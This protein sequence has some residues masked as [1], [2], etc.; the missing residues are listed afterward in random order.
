MEGWTEAEPTAALPLLTRINWVSMWIPSNADLKLYR[1]FDHPIPVKSILP[2]ASNSA[3]VAAHKFMP[4][5]SFQKKWR[6]A[7]KVIDGTLVKRPP[8]VR[9]IRYPCRKDAY[10]FKYYRE[11]LAARYETLLVKESIAHCVLAYRQIPKHPHTDVCKSNIEF[12]K[13][14]IEA[15][16]RIGDCCVVAIDISDFF[17]S[18]DHDRIK[19]TWANLL[20][21]DHLPEDHFSVFK[22]LTRFSYADRDA[23]YVALGFSKRETDGTLRYLRHPDSI[24]LQICS[25][26]QFREKIVGGGL[27][28]KH[29]KPYGIPQGCPLS[30]LIA[31]SYL[32]SFDVQMESYASKK[33]GCYFRYSD[34]ILFVLPGDGRTALPAFKKAAS[35]IQ[36]MGNNLLIKAEKTEVTLFKREGAFLKPSTLTIDEKTLRTKRKRQSDGMSYLGF[37]FD[38]ARI[39]LRNSTVSNVSGKMFRTC[40]AVALNH[41]DRYMDKDLPWLLENSPLD[42][43]AERFFQVRDFEDTVSEARV[44]GKDPYRKLT[45]FSYSKRAS[46]CFDP[47][48]DHIKDQAAKLKKQLSEMLAKQIIAKF[49]TRDARFAHKQ[50]EKRANSIAAST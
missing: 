8:K 18:M 6:R 17:G 27:V 42:E 9:D 1:H 21:V 50:A 15:V 43:V 29:D 38:G 12:A 45:F 3:A 26:K 39:Y 30:D 28:V 41:V 33:G 35:S 4:L 10:V 34:D 14:A 13:E 31:N 25:N 7:P 49:N 48:G 46:K 20:D 19:S 36:R 47:R 16:E 40:Q 22:A 11:I 2:M 23:A 24:P 5:I 32:L 37:R 44:S